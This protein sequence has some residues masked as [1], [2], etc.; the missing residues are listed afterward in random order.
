M[1]TVT[2][3]ETGSN[4]QLATSRDESEPPIAWMRDT[5]K[6]H[7]RRK[8]GNHLLRER[9]RERERENEKMRKSQ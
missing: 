6:A 7:L 2:A 8:T 5:S 9:E 4:N 3:Q 1:R